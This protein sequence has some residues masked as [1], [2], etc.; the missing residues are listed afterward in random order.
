M[1]SNYLTIRPGARYFHS[2]R[3]LQRV[4]ELDPKMFTKSGIMVGLGEERNEVLQL[5]DDLRSADVDFL[6]IG[7]YLQPTKKHARSNASSRPRSSRLRDHRPDQGFPD[8]LVLAADAFLAPCWRRFRQAEGGASR[9]QWP[10]IDPVPSFSTHHEVTHSARDM[11]ALVADVDAYP[12]FVP[13]CTAMVVK[14]R[15]EEEGKE[16]VVARMTV[17]YGLVSKSYLSRIVLDPEALT[18][19]VA[20]IDG[21]FRQLDNHWRFEPAGEKACRVHFDITYE[22]RSRT[23][24]MLLGGIFDRAFRRFAEAFEKRADALYGAGQPANP[25]RQHGGSRG[26]RAAK[27]MEL[28]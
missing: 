14:S 13:M 27:P 5:M 10:L 22:F 2:I 28:P 26:P 19:Q 8:G 18:I 23:L 16:T 21:P 7:Q 9:P 1:P 24:G 6:T 15:D 25:L 12:Q 11:F 4:K 3:L 17:G 20:A